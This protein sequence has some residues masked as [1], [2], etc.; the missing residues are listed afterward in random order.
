MLLWEFKCPLRSHNSHVPETAPGP[1]SRTWT[2][3]SL[4]E[5]ERLLFLYINFKEALMVEFWLTP[6]WTA[7]KNGLKRGMHKNKTRKI[8]FPKN[9]MSNMVK[10]FQTFLF[11]EP[12]ASD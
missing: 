6:N 10:F 2:K 3:F 11:L 5:T 4:E 8:K 1:I 7:T 9:A 12:A